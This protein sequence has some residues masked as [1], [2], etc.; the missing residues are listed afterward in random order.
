ML[1]ALALVRSGTVLPLNLPLDS[2]TVGRPNLVH[3]ARMHNETRPLPD[4]R[5]NVVNDDTVDLALQSHT[6]W[7]ALAHWGV[8]EPGDT[9]VFYGGAGLNETYPEFGAKT[10]GMGALAGGIVTRGVLFD[11]VEHLEGGNSP[12]LRD[13]TNFGADAV[14]SYLERKNLKLQPG[15]AAIFYTGFQQRLVARPQSW[16]RGTPGMTR[17]PRAFCRKRCRSGRRR[18]PSRSSPTTR[19]SSRTRWERVCCTPA[20]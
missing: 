3:H 17:S 10:L 7:D 11:M 4:G 15:D 20:R 8:I 16:S 1:A 13:G 2:P 19:R 9:G 6:H 14:T 5:F 18:R 12:Y